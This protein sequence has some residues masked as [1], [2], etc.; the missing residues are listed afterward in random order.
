MVRLAI[1]KTRSPIGRLSTDGMEFRFSTMTINHHSWLLRQTHMHYYS[2]TGKCGQANLC[3]SLGF[4]LV[5]SAAKRVTLQHAAHSHNV[6]MRQ[7]WH[8]LQICMDSGKTQAVNREPD[9]R[10]VLTLL[11]QYVPT[12]RPY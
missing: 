9:K 7:P 10:M 3:A 6:Q 8:L 1:V 2:N 5:C 11:F 4:A 12:I